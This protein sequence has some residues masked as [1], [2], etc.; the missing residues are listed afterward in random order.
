M[1]VTEQVIDK[2]YD[3]DISNRS[4]IEI[5][6]PLSAKLTSKRWTTAFNRAHCADYLLRANDERWD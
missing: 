1:T 4:Y 6:K 3:Y 2:I 5:F